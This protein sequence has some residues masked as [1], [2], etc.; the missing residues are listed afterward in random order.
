MLTKHTAYTDK[1]VLFVD[2]NKSWLRDHFNEFVKTKTFDTAEGIK[3]AL[4]KMKDSQYDIILLDYSLNDFASGEYLIPY[5]RSMQ[6]QAL[7]VANSAEFNDRLLAAGADV[8]FS[9]DDI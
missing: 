5:I 6:P 3:K 2:D 9:T 8:A 1:R 7:I 4:E